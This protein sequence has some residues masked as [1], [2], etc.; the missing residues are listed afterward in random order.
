MNKLLPISFML[1]FLATCSDTIWTEADQKEWDNGY[2]YGYQGLTLDKSLQSYSNNFIDGYEWGDAFGDCEYYQLKG[3]WNSFTDDDCAEEFNLDYPSSNNAKQGNYYPRFTSCKG[4][5]SKWNNCLGY[6]SF[7]GDK[8]IYAKFING[9]AQGYGHIKFRNGTYHGNIQY[10]QMHGEGVYV[11]NSGEYTYCKTFLNNK[12]HG[13][14]V[15]YSSNGKPE[16]VLNYYK[17]VVKS[18][19]YAR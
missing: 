15:Q 13:N 10:N 14:C 8:R 16:F 11:F 17:G 7:N 6:H 9:N 19:T 18:Q 5:K 4:D 12:F 3:D 1:L 2:N